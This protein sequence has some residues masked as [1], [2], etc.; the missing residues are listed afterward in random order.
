MVSCT[1]IALDAW[2]TSGVKMSSVTSRV[3][4]HQLTKSTA[5]SL[6]IWSHNPSD[7]MIRKSPFSHSIFVV[8][9]TA[10]AER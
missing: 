4:S 2:A 8:V 1:G 6:V 3:L 10:N 7:A 5:C 9:T